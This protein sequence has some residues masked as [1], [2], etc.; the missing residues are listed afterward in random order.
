MENISCFL[1]TKTL[2]YFHFV[3]VHLGLKA[4]RGKMKSFPRELSDEYLWSCLLG[5]PMTTC[6]SERSGL[7][8]DARLWVALPDEVWGP[9]RMGECRSGCCCYC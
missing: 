4:V 5:E 2:A 7:E 6:W 8:T 3:M 1:S 9:C